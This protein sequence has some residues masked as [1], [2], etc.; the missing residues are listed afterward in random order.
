[1]IGGFSNRSIF[2][3]RFLGDRNPMPIGQIFDSGDWSSFT[4]TGGG[5][6]WTPSGSDVLVSGGTSGVYANSYAHSWVTCLERHTI[7]CKFKVTTTPGASTVG[8]S[9]G[10]RS[11]NTI[12]K[13]TY[14]VLFNCQSGANGGKTTIQ[15]ANN[16]AATTFTNLVTSSTVGVNLNDEIEMV[17]VKNYLTINVWTYNVTQNAYSFVTYTDAISSP[18]TANQWHNTSKVTAYVFGGTYT[19]HQINY[20]TDTPNNIN[21]LCVGDSITVGFFCNTEDQ[22]WFNKLFYKSKK[23]NV[24]YG[25]AADKT[26][27]LLLR[28]PEI[29]LINPKYVVLMIGTND[30]R[31]AIAI[32]TIRANYLS[33]YNQLTRAGIKV[34]CCYVP[35]TNGSNV[36]PLNDWISNTL[37]PYMI[38]ENTFY[39]LVSTSTLPSPSLFNTDLVHP[40]PSGGIQIAK[41]I[42]TKAPFLI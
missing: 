13:I 25:G 41:D 7:S 42:K 24:R 37:N 4:A 35:P 26:A 6:T 39:N 17:I 11:V 28:I 2:H 33:F 8:M 23:S 34:I 29:L 10:L 9:F 32:A 12:S 14:N 40:N 5:A 30:I 22:T 19:L 36:T 31:S 20:S 16:A 1:M 3:N 15:F 21:C 38:V 27:E 18:S